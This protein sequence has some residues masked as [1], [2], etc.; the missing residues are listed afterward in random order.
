MINSSISSLSFNIIL[1]NFAVSDLVFL[2]LDSNNE[3]KSIF[4]L[5]LLVKILWNLL[6]KFE[7]LV[8]SEKS[9]KVSFSIF[10][11][12]SFIWFNQLFIDSLL[13]SECTV[14]KTDSNCY[15]VFPV[16]LIVSCNISTYGKIQL[17]CSKS[18]NAF[19]HSTFYSWSRS[20]DYSS[21]G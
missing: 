3:S 13:I 19:S 21:N 6:L 17:N 20:Q 14:A 9:I 15:L 10:S 11:R 1:T 18:F 8:I 4:Y 12:L 7:S 2:R 5:F 16:A